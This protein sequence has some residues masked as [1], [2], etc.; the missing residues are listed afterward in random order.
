[1]EWI[2]VKGDGLPI[3]DQIV[4]AY[5][6][7]P[8]K[9]AVYRLCQFKRTFCGKEINEFQIIEDGGEVG[10]EATHWMPYSEIKGN[11]EEGIFTPPPYDEI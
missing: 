2:S 6:D 8:V 7:A 4:L 10:M 3:H 5:M 9:G 1:M 11:R